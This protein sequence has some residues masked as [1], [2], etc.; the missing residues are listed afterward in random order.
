VTLALCAAAPFAIAQT[1]PP[2]KD[3]K[4]PGTG[5]AAA[6]ASAAPSASAS[7]G[8]GTD[9]ALA[10][11]AQPAASASGSAKTDFSTVST[12]PADQWS[13]TDVHEETGK[14]YMFIGARYRG[15]IVPK[16]LLNAFV[17]EGKTIYNND[18][19]FEFDLRKDGFSFVPGLHYM[20]LGTQDML[21]HQKNTPTNIPGNYSRVNSSMKTI[22][23][24]VDLLWST[25]LSPN[26]DI[27][28]GAGFGVGVLFG[29]LV[30]NWVREA[31]A[32]E[33]AEFTADTGR[34]YIRCKTEGEGG[35]GSGCN[36]ADHQNAQEAKVGDYTEKTWADGGSKPFLFLWLTPDVGLR[37][38][39]VKEF[40]ARVNIGFALTG[41]WFGISGYYGL[42]KKP[43]K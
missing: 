8:W 27:E 4:G 20:E 22:M 43:E 11:S 7:S 24:T 41:P 40:E 32:G 29:G 25:K 30:N 5:G 6:S 15:N 26:V 12:P 36:K 23:A 37:I 34:G 14:T 16:F 39:P 17:D 3:A 42:E 10:E 18:F 35:P 9:P 28:Y 19:G 21:F 33:V 31:K 13:H 2:A 1:K 38:K